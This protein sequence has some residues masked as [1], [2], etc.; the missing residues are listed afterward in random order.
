MM[1]TKSQYFQDHN[2]Q[3]SLY[4]LGQLD[5]QLCQLDQQSLELQSDIAA[6]IAA[7]ATVVGETLISYLI[8]DPGERLLLVKE[9]VRLTACCSQFRELRLQ[10]VDP[11]PPSSQAVAAPAA[12]QLGFRLL[13]QKQN[14]LQK[15]VHG[16]AL[17]KARG[18]TCHFTTHTLR[19]VCTFPQTSLIKGDMWSG[20]SHSR[21]V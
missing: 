5:H 9:W 12:E 16:G 8:R 20:S 3:G 11:Q 7:K 10:K 17:E 13:T 18:N 21:R 4:Q 2:Q 19:G 1:R 15:K 14:S 6:C